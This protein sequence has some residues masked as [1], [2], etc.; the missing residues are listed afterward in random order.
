M[1]FRSRS[2]YSRSA[3]SYCQLVRRS[4]SIT[5]SYNGNSR[6]T[7]CNQK[8][9]AGYQINGQT[10]LLNVCTEDRFQRY[11]HIFPNS[12]MSCMSNI[13]CNQN[14][15]PNAKFCIQSKLFSSSSVLASA[16]VTPVFLQAQDF[17]DRLAVIS[18]HGRYTYMDVLNYSAKLAQELKKLLK[19]TETKDDFSHPRIGFLCENDL[20]YVVT[21]WAIFMVGGIAVPLCKQHPTNEMQYFIEDSGASIIVGTSE[22][23]DKVRPIAIQLGV[24]MMILTVDDYTDEVEDYTDWLAGDYY[25]KDFKFL[26]FW[27]TTYFTVNTVKFNIRGSTMV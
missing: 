6:K 2:L 10:K 27:A 16:I 19:N 3:V 5:A 14:F 13:G 25:R 8:R 9:G 12:C 11:F 18:Q 4:L 17:A 23:A 15:I 24:P 1:L 7:S 21:Q 22:F 20:S 26:N